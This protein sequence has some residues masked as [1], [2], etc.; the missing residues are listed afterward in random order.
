MKLSKEQFDLIQEA[1]K[2]PTAYSWLVINLTTKEQVQY[3]SRIGPVSRDHVLRSP[4]VLEWSK[5]AEID[6]Y[7]AFSTPAS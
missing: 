6:C 5:N 7:P 3:N 4:A 2:Q 1:L